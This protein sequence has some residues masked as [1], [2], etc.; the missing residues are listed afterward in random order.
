MAADM[1]KSHISFG[2]PRYTNYISVT[3]STQGS[4]ASSVSGA[5]AS[6]RAAERE[7]REAQIRAQ[8]ASSLQLGDASYDERSWRSH[9]DR[10]EPTAAQRREA[11]GQLDPAVATR[12][13]Q[14]K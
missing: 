3:R 6:T 7:Q 10:P 5:S 12:I 1:R 8:K 2:D 13:R 9:N 14:S 11:R 4:V